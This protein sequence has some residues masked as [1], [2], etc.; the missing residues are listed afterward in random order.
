MQIQKACLQ[1]VNDQR[2]I[3]IATCTACC[4][5][6]PASFSS[7]R[8]RSGRPAEHSPGWLHLERVRGERRLDVIYWLKL[9][10]NPQVGNSSIPTRNSIPRHP[11]TDSIQRM[12]NRPIS[13]RLWIALMAWNARHCCLP[14]FACRAP[15]QPGLC[16]IS[17]GGVH[18]IA[19]LLQPCRNGCPH[20]LG[21]R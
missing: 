21:P 4:T 5:C 17:S 2:Y 16:F 3:S 8:W 10:I 18:A 11:I 14:A 12:I 9:S 7:S 13:N 6:L 15:E 20:C 1:E 19:Q